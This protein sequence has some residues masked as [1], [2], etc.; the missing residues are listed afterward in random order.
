MT[1]DEHYR[2]PFEPLLPGVKFVRAN[3]PAALAAAVSRST[4]AIIAEPVQGEGGIRPLT[5]AFASAITEA[6][7]QDRRAASSPTKSRAVWAGPAIR[8]TSRRSA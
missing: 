6:C 3:D 1:S 5:P 4:A 7:A 2:A 8:S